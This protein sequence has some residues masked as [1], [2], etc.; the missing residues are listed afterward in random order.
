MGRVQH[1]RKRSGPQHRRDSVRMNV[2][3][4]YMSVWAFK[5]LKEE[6]YTGEEEQKWGWRNRGRSVASLR[7]MPNLIPDTNPPRILRCC[8]F[9]L[10]FFFWANR[11]MEKPN[12]LIKA[13][14]WVR[15]QPGFLQIW[16]TWIRNRFTDEPRSLCAVVRALWWFV[17]DWLQSHL[18][19]TFCQKLCSDVTSRL[20]MWPCENTQVMTWQ[21]I[22]PRATRGHCANLLCII[23]G[24][25]MGPWIHTCLL[26][27]V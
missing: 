27:H 25:K 11:T 26:V 9:S 20:F 15:G 16:K 8:S 23:I 22:A 2:A 24:G 14:R 3:H 5:N 18:N 21:L 13:C 19:V 12:V 17:C 6:E 4:C 1:S 10:F 7:C